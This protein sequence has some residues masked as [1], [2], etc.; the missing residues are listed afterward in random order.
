MEIL[1]LILI[2]GGGIFWYRKRKV[3]I[4]RTESGGMRFLD[5][6]LDELAYQLHEERIRSEKMAQITYLQWKADKER[7]N[8]ITLT[9]GVTLPRSQWREEQDRVFSALE[10]SIE[11]KRQLFLAGQRRETEAAEKAAEVE[12]KTIEAIKKSL[13]DDTK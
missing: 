6:K 5:D 2:I 11:G 9:T 13:E 3:R 10:Q 1:F 4:N 7:E 8:R 12:R